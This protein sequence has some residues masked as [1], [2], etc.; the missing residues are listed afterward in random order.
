MKKDK[1]RLKEQEQRFKKLDLGNDIH[2]NLYIDS[3][4]RYDFLNSQYMEKTNSVK[5][6]NDRTF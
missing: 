1:K 6:N 4:E 5:R 3:R 2:S